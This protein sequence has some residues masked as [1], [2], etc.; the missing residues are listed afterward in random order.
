MSFITSL[1]LKNTVMVGLFMVSAGLFG[2]DIALIRGNKQ[3]SMD[4]QEARR[5]RGLEAL[6]GTLVPPLKGI[7]LSGEPLDISYNTR[8][9]TLL[10]IFSPHCGF[11][12]KNWPQWKSLLSSL[13]RSRT[14]P[15][16]VDLS[17]TVTTAFLSAHQI[18]TEVLMAHV[19]PAAYAKYSLR[20]TPQT[21]LINKDGVVSHVWT[22]LLTN[23]EQ[24][25]ILAYQAPL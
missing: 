23:S 24:K 5:S 16:L 2:A 9:N 8:Q 19:D 15:V 11:C 25:E 1:S 18:S 14:Q 12:E 4:L 3:L 22:G 17:S 13:D 7:G 10:L 6:P 21:I 20:I